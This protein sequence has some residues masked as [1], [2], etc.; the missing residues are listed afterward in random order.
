MLR[1]ADWPMADCH[2]GT[3]DTLVVHI[4]VGGPACFLSVRTERTQDE[5]R[6]VNV[7]H[8]IAQNGHFG[9][10]W[11][12][13]PGASAPATSGSMP[14]RPTTEYPSQGKRGRRQQIF[15]TRYLREAVL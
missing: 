6:W 10:S 14:C 1:Q 13:G 8:T 9:C 4:H 5:E 3:P 15:I 12:S 7:A 11:I 2:E